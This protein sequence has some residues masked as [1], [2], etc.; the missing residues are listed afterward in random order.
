MQIV[1]RALYKLISIYKFI[2]IWRRRHRI[3]FC[4]CPQTVPKGSIIIFPCYLNV[5]H[6]GLLGILEYKKKD[7][8]DDPSQSLEAIKHKIED[9]ENNNL[10]K[11]ISST[12]KPDNYCGGKEEVHKL[13]SK[14]RSLK[15]L[16]A[17]QIIYQE[18]KLQ[19]EL[20]EV[21]AKIK[22]F[23]ADEQ[24]SIK[25]EGIKLSSQTLEAV[26]QNLMI[27]KDIAWWFEKEILF[28]VLK[29]S[30]LIKTNETSSCLVHNMKKITILLNNLDRLE[31][32]GRD[33]AGISVM[34]T[35]NDPAVYEKYNSSLASLGLDVE[36]KERQKIVN[37]C[38]RSI[39]VNS[40]DGTVRLNFVYKTAQ[41]IGH[42][43]ENVSKL[44][45]YIAEDQLLCELLNFVEN[46][47]QVL[48]HTRWASSPGR[49]FTRSHKIRPTPL[50]PA[51]C[52]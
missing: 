15:T 16:E 11:V 12:I 34:V 8:V 10:K 24:K 14:A 32:R 21:T 39:T 2:S 5:L 30:D 3:Y 28:D 7:K 42:L 1:H 4:K 17:F 23:I 50:F 37:F 19:D 45:G 52:R 31:V 49:P 13:S 46:Q 38:N 36:F 26:N 22:N 44:R 41:V 47:C 40:A 48:A 25:E 35:L 20:R 6:C 43:G 33:S 18:P 29:V 27:L 51:S 9:I